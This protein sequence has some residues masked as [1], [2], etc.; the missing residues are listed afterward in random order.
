MPKQQHR[1][2]LQ[3]YAH[4]HL[5]NTQHGLLVTG[6][7]LHADQHPTLPQGWTSLQKEQS[8][9]HRR[10]EELLSDGCQLKTSDLDIA[11]MVR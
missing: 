11:D 6:G 4:L 3:V 7:Q 2:V 10:P 5:P 9:Q 8:S 1:H